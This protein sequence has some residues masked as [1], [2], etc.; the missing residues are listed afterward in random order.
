MKNVEF[1]IKYLIPL[2][3]E[4]N[5]GIYKCPE[6]GEELWPDSKMGRYMI[7]LSDLPIPIWEE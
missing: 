3:G 1:D 7:M 5:C 4:Y 2:T 6:C